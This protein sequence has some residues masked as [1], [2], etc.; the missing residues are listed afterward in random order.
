MDTVPRSLQPLFILYGYG[1]GLAQFACHCLINWTCRIRHEGLET[2]PADRNFI[3]CVWH[4]DLQSYFCVFLRHRRHTWMMHPSWYMI[5][6]RFGAPIFVDA[7]N[8]E[9]AI[10]ATAGAL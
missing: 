5:H 6:V 8:F 4:G 10:C 9:S 3:Y 2:L 7:S 1:V